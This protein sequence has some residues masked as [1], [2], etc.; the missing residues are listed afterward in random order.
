M[1]AIDWVKLEDGASF[2]GSGARNED[3]F[4]FGEDLL[5]VADGHVVFV[6]DALPDNVPFPSPAPQHTGD[7]SGN[8]I[9]LEIAPGVYAIYAH[10][11]QGSAQVRAGDIVHTGDVLGKLGNSG[12]ADGTDAPHLHFQLS[13][14]PD[15][16]TSTSLPYVIDTWTLEGS[17]SPER[18]TTDLLVAPSPVPQSH[19]LPLEGSVASFAE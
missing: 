15:L 8:Q 4:A 17:T 3:Y 18:D 6:S 11:Q 1:F 5:A 13:D 16:M 14:G 7:S 9:V 19:T 10:V 2:S 12:S